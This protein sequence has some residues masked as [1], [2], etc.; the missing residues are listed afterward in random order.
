MPEWYRTMLSRMERPADPTTALMD[1][2][3]RDLL[4]YGDGFVHY[5]RDAD[6]TVHVERLDPVDVI[7]V[8]PEPNKG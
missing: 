7:L 6:G 1:Q 3:K 5:R 2:I 8:R 4:L